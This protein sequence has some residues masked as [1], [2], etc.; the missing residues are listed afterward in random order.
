M[1][2]EKSIGLYPVIDFHVHPFVPTKVLLREME[3]SKVRMAVLLAIDVNINIIEKKEVQEE[4]RKRFFSSL[5]SLYN[6]YFWRTYDVVEDIRDFF[7]R[8]AKAFPDLKITNEEVANIVKEYPD[9]FVGFGSV[10][11][12]LSKN[13]LKEKLEEISRL[14]LKGIKLLPT[15]QFFNPAKNKNFY[16]ICKFCED[17][18]KIILIHTGCD[19]GPWE[20]PEIAEDANPKYLA[21]VLNQYRPTIVLAHAG[22]Y[23]MYEPGIWLDEALKLAQMFDNVY[24]DT[25]AVNDI[26]FSQEFLSKIRGY[27]GI[28]RLI[29]GSDYPI[30]RNSSMKDEVRCV[31]ECP[32]LSEQEKAMILYNNASSLL[33]IKV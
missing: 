30:L 24:F 12:N 7:K 22:S 32:H 15:I 14:E 23:S 27:L 11:P 26:L 3:E 4:L 8:M 31:N 18:D 33:R 28:E 25:S 19:P 20:I 1:A 16:K 9:R 2:K 17:N 10:N 21:K 5:H 6:P 29:F 13:A